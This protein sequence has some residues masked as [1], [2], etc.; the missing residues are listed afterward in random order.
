MKTYL[1]TYGFQLLHT[2]LVLSLQEALLYY[3]CEMYLM[4]FSNKFILF[5]SLISFFIILIIAV[6]HQ[7]IVQSNQIRI[8]LV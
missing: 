3:Y 8:A 5:I 6:I 2:V 4:N 1:F 7:T